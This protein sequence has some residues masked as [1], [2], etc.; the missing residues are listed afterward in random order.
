MLL[1]CMQAP[2]NMLVDF[3]FQDIIEA[4]TAD[5]YKVQIASQQVRRRIGDQFN[6]VTDHARGIMRSS[7][8]YARN[9][10]AIVPDE[11]SPLQRRLS[12]RLSS[13][14]M[15]H[16]TLADASTRNIPPAVMQLYSSTAMVLKDVFENSGDT[17]SAPGS[18]GR[19]YDTAERGVAGDHNFSSYDSFYSTW[20]D[21]SEQLQ[22][23]AKI[24][25]QERWGLDG[26]VDEANVHELVPLGVPAKLRN[27]IFGRLLNP[28]TRK[29]VLLEAL[30][31]SVEE[32]N[33]K[34]SKLKVATDVQVGLEVMHLFIMDLLG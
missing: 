17:V 13:S 1:A 3:L 2:V 25:F 33:D 12:R 27:V 23:S 6:A 14:V 9:V 18:P 34:I 32:A 29:D 28:T 24:E 31:E 30:T 26:D 5:A 20:L 22:G 16:F 21:Q 7:V 4:P 8:S 15:D 11:R 10:L 19:T